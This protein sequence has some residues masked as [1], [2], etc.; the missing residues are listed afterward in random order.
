MQNCRES[1][2]VRI[3]RRDEDNPQHL[4]GLVETVG[5]EGPTVF[6]NPEELWSILSQQGL[7]GEKQATTAAIK[8]TATEKKRPGHGLDE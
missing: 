7:N 8:Q 4:V 2:I 3:Y 6:N 5:V 1:Y